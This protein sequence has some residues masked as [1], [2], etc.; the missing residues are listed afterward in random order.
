[1]SS[2][3]AAYQNTNGSALNVDVNFYQALADGAREHTA[4]HLVPIR[5]GFAWEVPAGHIFRITT[6]QGRRLAI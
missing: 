4:S 3:P 1:M 2:Y 5:S 6:P